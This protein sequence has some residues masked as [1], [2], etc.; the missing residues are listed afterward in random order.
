MHSASVAMLPD[1]DDTG[2]L[3][4][5]NQAAAEAFLAVLRERRMV[6]ERFVST[7][8]GDLVI[9]WPAARLF[10]EVWDGRIHVSYVPVNAGIRQ[11]IEHTTFE[12]WQPGDACDLIGW[13]LRKP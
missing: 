13:Y 6:D 9:R 12:A 11:D 3:A 4:E 10:G 2:Q 8:L 5:E 7:C 1:D